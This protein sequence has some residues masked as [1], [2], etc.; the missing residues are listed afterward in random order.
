MNPS[1]LAPC[2]C[3]VLAAAPERRLSRPFVPPIGAWWRRFAAAVAAPGQGPAQPILRGSRPGSLP[4]RHKA[5]RRWSTPSTKRAHSG[6]ARCAAAGASRHS[7]SA[8]ATISAP[9]RT[10]GSTCTWP[11]HLVDPNRLN[12]R[13]SY[14]GPLDVPHAWADLPDWARAFAAA[15]ERGGLPACSCRCCAAWHRCA[16]R[17]AC[18]MRWTAGR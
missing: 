9:P 11:E 2:S 7:S 3:S 1:I 8:P 14:P 13:L 4:W 12:K 17:T 5:R 16:T 6:P 15:A 18:R 10:P